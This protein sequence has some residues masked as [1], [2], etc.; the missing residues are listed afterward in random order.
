M[1]VWMCGNAEAP[2]A[3]STLQDRIRR[4][5]K[6]LQKRSE[7]DHDPPRSRSPSPPRQ[8]P[9]PPP[10]TPAQDDVWAYAGNATIAEEP[11]W[12]PLI[13]PS[14]LHKQQRVVMP[15]LKSDEVILS[16]TVTR[17][18]RIEQARRYV[19]G[20]RDEVSV[21]LYVYVIVYHSVTK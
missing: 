16:E 1:C 19:Y 6:S 9:H 18:V 11:S 5:G 15:C 8:H 12:G 21:F 20:R 7:H 14:Q 10:S 17:L 4:A 13:P 2:V 3:A